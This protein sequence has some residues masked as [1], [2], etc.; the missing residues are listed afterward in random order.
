MGL[1]DGLDDWSM[2][3]QQIKYMDWI[4]FGYKTK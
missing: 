3:N 1:L 2:I 4:E